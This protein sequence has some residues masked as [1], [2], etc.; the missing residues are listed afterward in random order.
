M[1]DRFRCPQCGKRHTKTYQYGAVRGRSGSMVARETFHP[2]VVC[3]C[4]AGIFGWEILGGLHDPPSV[5]LAPV[6]RIAFAGVANALFWGG[7][8]YIFGSVAI[9]LIVGLVMLVLIW[10][11]YFA[12]AIKP[13]PYS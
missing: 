9:A 6:V 3:S 13:K 10:G 2:D 11:A 5:T 1:Q 4:G 7:I 12:G 8:A